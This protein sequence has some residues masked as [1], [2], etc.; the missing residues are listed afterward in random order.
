MA[1]VMT[2]NSLIA[3]I[4]YYAERTDTVFVN[5]QIPRIVM[6]AENR[7]ASEARGLGFVE[8]VTST[9]VSG[10]SF[11]AKPARWRETIS[12]NIGIGAGNNERKEL[13]LRSYE[14]CRS[15]WPNGTLL[16]EPKYYADWNYA[17]WLF[18]PTPDQNY[19]CEILYHQRP[20]PLDT[21]TQTNWTTVYAPQLLLYACLL[22]TQPFLKRDDRM[23]LFQ[24]EYD[25]A[26]KQVAFEDKRRATDRSQARVEN[27]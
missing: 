22:E 10:Q 14:Y 6:T 9:L 15:Y 11:L 23:Q 12:F 24:Q 20:Q 19:P 13:L 21:T 27:A 18:V 8:T 7:I 2:Y 16:A 5:T 17:N 25:R 4:Q 1:A 26:L 3:D